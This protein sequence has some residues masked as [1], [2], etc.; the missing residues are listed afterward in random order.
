[1]DIEYVKELCHKRNQSNIDTAPHK[2]EYPLCIDIIYQLTNLT[3]YMAPDY[4]T[5]HDF[6]VLR[7]RC[8]L[9][10]ATTVASVSLL[11]RRLFCLAAT[12]AVQSRPLLFRFDFSA[13]IVTVV[14]LPP[15]PPPLLSHRCCCPCLP[16]SATNTSS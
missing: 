6:S 10:T 16:T 13:A 15:L 11:P 4:M 2:M 5:T 14:L 9:T 7:Q 12:A 3:C 8:R 1:M